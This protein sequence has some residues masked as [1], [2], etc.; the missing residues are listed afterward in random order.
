MMSDVLTLLQNVSNVGEGVHSHIPHL[1]GRSLGA[2]QVDSERCYL[3]PAQ[4]AQ[5]IRCWEC[6]RWGED[7]HLRCTTSSDETARHLP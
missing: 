3:L 2:L 6:A 7:L 5:Q 1:Y 4:Y